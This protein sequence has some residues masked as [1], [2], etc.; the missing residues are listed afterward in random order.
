MSRTMHA[1]ALAAALALGLSSCASSKA[2]GLPLG[3]TE[4][5]EASNEVLVVD[6]AYRPKS[7]TV[8]AGTEVLWKQ[9][10]SAPHSVTSDTD[11][12]DSHPNCLQDPSNSCMKAGDEF[13]YTFDKAGS[14]PYYCVIHGG[15]GGVNMAG[16][17]VV[18]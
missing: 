10:G 9:T 6:S 11:L 3:P 7:L 5:P 8:E 1:L 4:P 15:K 2:T 13:K 18:T 17:V 14:Y 12:F 16:T